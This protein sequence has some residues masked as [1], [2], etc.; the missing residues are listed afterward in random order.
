MM[1]LNLHIS[2][3][4]FRFS[5]PDA[6][7]SRI[8]D[9]W[10]NAATCQ[11][12]GV[13]TT[14]NIIG[15]LLFKIIIEAVILSEKAG[16]FVHHI[17]CDGATW[18]RK[19]WQL[20]WLECVLLQKKVECKTEHPINSKRALHF[21]SDFPHLIKCLRNGL[22]KTGFTTPDGH[23][24]QMFWALEITTMPCITHTFPFLFT[25]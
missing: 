4:A 1:K 11:I 13:F 16:L 19:M 21:V 3:L 2:D 20:N 7:V 23:V 18:N 24:S 6:T 17:S 10:L 12:T 8:F 22:L 25:I 9:K 5:V 15:D 14:K